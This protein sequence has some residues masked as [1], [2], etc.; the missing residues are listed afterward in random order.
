MLDLFDRLLQRLQ[1]QQETVQIT[2]TA[3]EG[4]SPARSGTLMLAGEG[5]WSEGTIG[6]GAL[7]HRAL[8]TAATLLRQHHGG[9]QKYQLRDGA[10]SVSRIELLYTYWNPCLAAEAVCGLLC[11][12]GRAHRTTH[13][14]LPLDGSLPLGQ[15]GRACYD[16]VLTC[17]PRALV[18]GAGHVA[19]ALVPLLAELGWRCTV[20]DGRPERADTALFPDAE[21][22]I[23][24]D[25]LEAARE[26][27]ITAQDY[28]CIMTP[29]HETDL[30]LLL[31]VLDSRAKY[32]GVLGSADKR[33]RAEALLEE[34]GLA[35]EK[36]DRVALPIGLHI[37]S[38]TPQEIAVSIAAQMIRERG[39]AAQEAAEKDP[40]KE[41]NAGELPACVPDGRE[42]DA[43]NERPG[44]EKAG[45]EQPREDLPPWEETFPENEENKEELL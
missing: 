30:E 38:R 9:T 4:T 31:E 42:P 41:E 36:L 40:E 3:V 12:E 19:A 5:G 17:E 35:P 8:Q 39:A 33:R 25:V 14:A 18:F 10:G 24:R 37:Y 23:C 15:P 22:V 2:V 11:T 1:Q 43:G 26:M 28:L 32:I 34:K 16:L 6:G 44:E 27:K 45:P 7:E 13:L 29:D 21:E 20:V